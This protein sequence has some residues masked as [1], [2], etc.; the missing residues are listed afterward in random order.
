[1]HLDDC[2]IEIDLARL[3]NGTVDKVDKT[4]GGQVEDVTGHNC[5]PPRVTDAKYFGSLWAPSTTYVCGGSKPSIWL[6]KFDSYPMP[7]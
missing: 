1:M 5:G 6:T 2:E 7:A 3:R 4:R